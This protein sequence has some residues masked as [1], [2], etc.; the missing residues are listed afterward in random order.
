MPANPQSSRSA[1]STAL[2]RTSA[3]VERYCQA[4]EQIE[5]ADADLARE[6]KIAL[7]TGVAAREVTRSTGVSSKHVDAAAAREP[8]DY[9]C[10]EARGLLERDERARADAEAERLRVAEQLERREAH[11]RRRRNVA[12]GL[13]PEPHRAQP[14]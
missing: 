14:A 1:A 4:L 11:D 5:E 7:E 3:A 6:V 12:D 10:S 13:P 9:E 2:R 8:T